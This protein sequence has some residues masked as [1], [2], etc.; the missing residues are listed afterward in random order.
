MTA[1]P[2]RALAE[3]GQ[4]IWY[5]Q[6]S[7][8]LVADGTLRRLIED[9]SLR[10]MTSNPAIF[11]K[12]IGGGAEYGRPLGE[13]A[14]AGQDALSIYEDLATGDVGAAADLF[15]PLYE[16][17]D[18]LDGYV[19]IEVDPRLA[20]DTGAT[21][22]EARRLWSRLDR[23]NIMIK[24]PATAA[25]LPAIETLLAEGINVN[26][27][28]IFSL[29]VHRRVMDAHAA[30]IRRRALEGKDVSRVASVASFFVSRIDT[31]VDA[32]LEEKARLGTGT[33][34]LLSL[35]GKAAI[36]NAKL[37]YQS[38]R[39]HGGAQ[40]VRALGARPQRPLWASTGTKNPAYSDVL[41]VEELVGPETV[42]TVP[43]ATFDACRDHAR[44]ALTLTQGLDD[45]RAHFEMLAE[46]GVSIDEVTD[47]LARD[48]VQAF[49]DSF[50]KLLGVVEERRR[51]SLS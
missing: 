14:R 27:T 30:A 37:A 4:S 49:I 25:G 1:H 9:D 48:G 2:I 38:W 18:G 33:H 45:C 28:L 6:L 23:P 16:S 8:S 24:V 42:N 31:A 19:S 34:H 36:A 10:G 26:V 17:T 11:E 40:G 5:D 7:R 44:T 43:P 46:A 50:D 22:A 51:A 41:Y 21:I 39:D 3:L 29:E 20:H 35:R 15:R 12:S 47:K 13:L 32:L